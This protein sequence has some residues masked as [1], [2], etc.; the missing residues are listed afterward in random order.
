MFNSSEIRL[1]DND[2]IVSKT[3]LKGNITYCNDVFV[4]ISG[5]TVNELIGASHNIIR[6]PDMPKVAFKLAWQKIKN[7]EDFF[8]FVKNKSKDGKFYWVFTYISPDYKDGQII[9]YTS[10][11]RQPNYD[12]ISAVENIYK[13]LIS[14][15]RISVAEAEKHLTSLLNSVDQSYNEFV[16]NLQKGKK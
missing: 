12:V 13:E 15:E 6:H 14:K 8:G 7:G 3:D 4:K 10:I 5:Y 11:R 1:G 16:V 9:G 2:F